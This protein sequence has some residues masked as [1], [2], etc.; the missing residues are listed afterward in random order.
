MIKIHYNY[1]P[2]KQIVIQEHIKNSIKNTVIIDCLTNDVFINGFKHTQ[3]YYPSNDIN[4]Y[5]NMIMNRIKNG[6]VKNI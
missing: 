3:K 4:E 2:T 1:L 5:A 6:K